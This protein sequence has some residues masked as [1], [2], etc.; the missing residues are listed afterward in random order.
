[1]VISIRSIKFQLTT[2]ALL[3]A[4]AA[5]LASAAQTTDD[6]GANGL[7]VRGNGTVDDASVPTTQPVSSPAAATDRLGW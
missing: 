1:M 2:A 6:V 5:S 7:K 3:G 4:L